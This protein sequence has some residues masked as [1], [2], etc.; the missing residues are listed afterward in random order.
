MQHQKQTIRAVWML[1]LGMVL[2]TPV[3]IW[4][5]DAADAPESV[6]IDTLA[7]LYT[8]VEFDH[9]AHVDM[10]ECAAC[11]HHTTG[12]VPAE[13][14][15][16][17]CHNGSEGAVTVLCS[18]CHVARPFLHKNL[19]KLES[20]EIFHVDKPG[21]KGAYHLKCVGCHQES[22]GPTGCQDC[23]PMTEQGEKQFYTGK[24]TPAGYHSTLTPVHQ[25]EQAANE[26][27]VGDE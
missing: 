23:H 13:A 18:D 6:D 3:C 7:L 11:H 21:L 20:P 15:C 4:A 17:R 14:S 16:A 2:L 12:D 9:A 25:L 22:G 10:V 1:S 27:E 8:A 24:Y 5:M 26:P 19:L